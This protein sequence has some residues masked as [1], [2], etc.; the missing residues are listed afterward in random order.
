MLGQQTERTSA[1]C[2][3]L[4]QSVLVKLV[5]INRSHVHSDTSD[6]WTPEEDAL[7]LSTRLELIVAGRDADIQKLDGGDM[8]IPGIDSSLPYRI[9]NRIWTLRKIFQQESV[10]LMQRKGSC[11]HGA[12]Y[13][14]TFIVSYFFFERTN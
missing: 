8:P 14:Y 3:K 2:A 13:N 4:P 9:P 5:Q 1:S 7:L 6:P 10:D 11:M 12:S